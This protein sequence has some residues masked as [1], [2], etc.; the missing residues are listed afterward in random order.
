MGM[1]A[2]R[3]AGFGAVLAAILTVELRK[4]SEYTFAMLGFAEE[5]DSVLA[6]WRNATFPPELA[7]RLCAVPWSVQAQHPESMAFL[8]CGRLEDWRRNPQYVLEEAVGREITSF[9][10]VRFLN[11]DGCSGVVGRLAQWHDWLVGRRWDAVLDVQSAVHL[12]S[13]GSS[14]VMSESLPLAIATREL[15]E[16]KRCSHQQQLLAGPSLAGSSGWDY[17]VIREGAAVRPTAPSPPHG[18]SRFLLDLL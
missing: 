11:V 1:K 13:G 7:Q 12:A 17:I 9:T 10:W 5:Q 3:S 8:F 15:L 16:R 14:P 6:L 2:S 4:P 18:T